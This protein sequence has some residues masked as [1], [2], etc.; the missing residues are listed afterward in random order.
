M[1]LKVITP[2]SE[3]PVTLAE[4]KSQCRVRHDD[5]DEFLEGLI[6]SATTYVEATLS[7]T[8][9]VRTYELSLDEFTDAIELLRGPATAVTWVRY[10][11][12]DG[13]TAT[14]S[15]DDYTVDLISN[16]Q[17]V[18]V[19][20]GVS[21]P[22][23]LDAINAVTVRYTAGYDEVPD[24]LKHAILLLIGHWYA[25]REAANV[26]NTIPREIPL[27]V[28]ALLQSYRFILV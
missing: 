19:N 14:V 28:D 7:Q 10:V 4:A 16:R 22:S 6:R 27:A 12:E 18:V 26:G 11:D 24:D 1:G 8:I 20:S 2:P 23:T 13:E 9:A 17:W 25:N 21:W 5:E 15:A 3:W